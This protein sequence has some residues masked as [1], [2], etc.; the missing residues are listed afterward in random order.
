MYLSY[1]EYINFGGTVS[2]AAFSRLCYKACAEIDELTAGRAGNMQ[3]I[4]DAVRMCA[5][6]LIEL[7]NSENRRDGVTSASNDGVSVTYA[8]KDIEKEAGAVIRSYLGNISD[9]SGTPLLYLGVM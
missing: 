8:Q 1:D 6:E 9:D 2:E 3:D 4:P 7:F 5:V